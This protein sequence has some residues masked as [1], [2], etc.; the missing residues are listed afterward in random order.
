MALD[1]EFAFRGCTVKLTNQAHCLELNL[2][3]QTLEHLSADELAE[4][5]DWF[6]RNHSELRTVFRWQEYDYGPQWREK[7]SDAELE[8]V[9]ASEF[10]TDDDRSQAGSI[11]ARRRNV[12]PVGVQKIAQGGFVYLMHS[13]SGHY[14]I[15]ASANPQSRLRSLRTA[16]PFDI[17]IVHTVYASDMFEAE[18]TLHT[19]YA[20]KRVSNEW[21]E[22]S[23]FDVQAIQA[24]SHYGG[25]RFS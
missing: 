17:R 6:R 19:R 2:N 15:G 13:S 24:L 3:M 14:K 10:S 21:F 23:E 4:L 20:G 11:L 5:F 8:V 22:L 1:V 18:K 9:V 25:G 7:F 16:S 12:R